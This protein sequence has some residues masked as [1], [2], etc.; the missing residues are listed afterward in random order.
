M[1]LN[2]LVLQAENALV[3][4]DEIAR[5]DR[6]VIKNTPVCEI[7]WIKIT[8]TNQDEALKELNGMCRHNLCLWRSSSLLTV[9]I[10]TKF[11][12]AHTT[13]GHYVQA[14][15]ASRS[16]SLEEAAAPFQ[17]QHMSNMSLA[18]LRLLLYIRDEDFYKS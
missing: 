16:C 4:C 17:K 8:A 15:A 2:T 3:N 6:S 10:G 14:I 1:I 9:T 11:S 12:P 13:L 18:K 5:Q 7:I